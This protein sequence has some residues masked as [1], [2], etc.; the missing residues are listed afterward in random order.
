MSKSLT[1]CSWTAI[2]MWHPANAAIVAPPAH[3]A[4]AAVLLLVIATA[5]GNPYPLSAPRALVGATGGAERLVLVNVL[6]VVMMATA[7]EPSVASVFTFSSPPPHTTDFVSASAT[8]IPA[9][10][11]EKGRDAMM[12]VHGNGG[13][14]IVM[15]AA[16]G[17]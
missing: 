10:A 16:A 5:F 6:V 9:A 2:R 8:A 17:E 7:T 13:G 3:V 4:G 15:V 14:G 1:P 12:R 11:W